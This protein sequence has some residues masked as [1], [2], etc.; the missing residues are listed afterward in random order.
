MKS[1]GQILHF[2]DIISVAEPL[3]FESQLC[4]SLCDLEQCFSGFHNFIKQEFSKNQFQCWIWDVILQ[5]YCSQ[6][7]FTHFLPCATVPST[8]PV[9]CM[10]FKNFPKLLCTG[11]H[12][13]VEE[14]RL[15]NLPKGIHLV[16]GTG[17][18]QIRAIW[19]QSMLLATLRLCK[20]NCS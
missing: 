8:L 6:L 17:V 10:T 7:A 5:S 14:L 12:F 19:L 18:V 9:F 20:S 2:L 1:H 11:P 13:I 3:Q 15:Y 4:F 16:N